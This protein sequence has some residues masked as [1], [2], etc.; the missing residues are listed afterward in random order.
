M[1]DYMKEMTIEQYSKLIKK[2]DI[3]NADINYFISFMDELMVG[4]K[5]FNLKKEDWT[6]IVEVQYFKRDEQAKLVSDG[7]LDETYSDDLFYDGLGLE[8]N[9]I[10]LELPAF[11]VFMNKIRV[12][13]DCL[14][15]VNAKSW[16][17]II[18]TLYYLNELE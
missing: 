1:T 10:D 17:P 18:D 16:T 5:Y 7:K 11:N 13:I 4:V 9:I 3:L 14:F 8:L 6:K 12:G 2:L 15:F